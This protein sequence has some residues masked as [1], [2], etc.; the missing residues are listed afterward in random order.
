MVIIVQSDASFGELGLVLRLVRRLDLASI[1]VLGVVALRTHGLPLV[2]ARVVVLVQQLR[3]VGPR[4]LDRRDGEGDVTVA[5]SLAEGDRGDRLVAVLTEGYREV[6]LLTVVHDDVLVEGDL[7]GGQN[8]L[9]AT[10]LLLLVQCRACSLVRRRAIAVALEV[11]HPVAIV[12]GA[13]SLAVLALM[14]AELLQLCLI[15]LKGGLLL[16]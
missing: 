5:V 8:L 4:A 16:T 3:V 15:L 12:K 10:S 13:A 7:V 2:S 1:V 14:L 6:G 11:M 9:L